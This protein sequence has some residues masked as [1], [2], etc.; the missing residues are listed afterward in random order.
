MA[1]EIPIGATHETNVTV[2]P[3]MSPPH[4]GD[5]AV[6][7]TPSMINLMEQCALQAMRP[8]LTDEETSVGTA[9]CIT[10]DAALAVG[11]QATVKSRLKEM[12]GRRYVW[13]VE[14]LGPDGK[15]LGGGT[16]TRAVVSLARLRG[17]R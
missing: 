4:L 12:E 14:A 5:V 1:T 2:T 13:E 9:V 11:Q 6:L 10:H 17:G 15:R 7:S 16:H 3:D 8:F